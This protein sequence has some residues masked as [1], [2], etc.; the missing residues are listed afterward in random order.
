MA[1]IDK[2]FDYLVP[3]GV[4]GSVD[5]GAEVRIDLSGRR[6]G[7][8]VTAIGVETGAGRAVRPIAKVRGFGPDSSTVDLAGWAAWRYA[9]RRRSLLVTASA[10]AAV[11]HLPPPALRA[12]ARPATSDVVRQI[13]GLGVVRPAVL[14]LPPAADPTEVV[15]ELAQRGPILVVVPT[16]AR[17]AVLAGRLRRAGGDVA[18]LPGGWPQ[19]RAGAAVVIGSRACAWAPCPGMAAAV[20]LDGHDESLT[21]EQSPTWGAVAVV[22]ERAKRAGVPCVIISSCPTPELL[23][24]GSLSLVPRSAERKGWAAI[25]VID[26]RDDDPR[27]GLYSERLVALIRSEPKVVCVLNRTG[28]ARLLAC[29]AC[30]SVASCERCGASLAQQKQVEGPTLLECSRCGL[31]RPQV[32]AECHSTRLR[33][34]RIGVSRAR[35][36][37]EALAGRPVA[38]VTGVT[39]TVPD[40]HLVVGTEAVL[41]RLGPADGVTAV[42]FVDFDQELF[43]GRVRAPSEALGLVALA[44]RIVRGRAGRIVIQTRSPKHPVL[45]AAVLADPAVLSSHELEVRQ[46]LRLPPFASIALVS[47]PA[48]LEYALG[49][50]GLAGT[51]VDVLGPDGDQW[52]VK[53]AD[54]ATLADALAAVPRPA[55][56]LRVAVEP[57]RL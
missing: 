11:P 10:G 12:P 21:Q 34:L 44:S 51:P 46:E 32:C 37:L 30:G 39:D 31:V 47:G 20:V 13:A 16:V 49:L 15:A 4:V 35:E 7:G 2:E 9:G 28:R 23:A 53:A 5:V 55:G 54:G 14:R 40:A 27:L 8:W 45:R 50:R 38:E 3:E 56:R 24:I 42:A 1:G 33:T 48:S 6:T 25:E 22:V 57:G 52:L 18:L 41:H 29:A 19:A 17:A 26:R 43:A 36:E